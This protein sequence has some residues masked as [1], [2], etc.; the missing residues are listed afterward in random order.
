[1]EM[2]VI[3]RK[4]V[5]GVKTK[6]SH[7]KLITKNTMKLKIKQRNYIIVLRCTDSDAKT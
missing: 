3:T 6:K 5:S 7:N 1:M 2:T 4:V